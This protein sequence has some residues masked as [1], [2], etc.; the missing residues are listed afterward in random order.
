[1]QAFQSSPVVQGGDTRLVA[2]GH[3]LPGDA[4]HGGGTRTV[5]Q[6]ARDVAASAAAVDP[7]ESPDD[8]QVHEVDDGAVHAGGDRRR[9]R[10]G[11]GKATRWPWPG[12]RRD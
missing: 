1:M 8:L 6:E 2:N 3:V 10:R 7:A 4:G 11:R 5:G 12:W 9:R